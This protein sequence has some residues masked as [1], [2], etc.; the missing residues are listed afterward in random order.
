MSERISVIKEKDKLI[1]TIKAFCD[2]QKQKMLLWWIV[3]F[4]ICGIV[5]LS[6]FFGNY[7]SGTKVF[8]AVYVA[9]WI[10]FEFKVV[11]AYRWRKYGEE[12]LILENGELLLIKNIGKRGVTQRIEFEEIQKVDFY[13]DTN[14]GFIK[15]M[16]DSYWNINKYNLII[17]LEN[18]VV[19]FA[20]DITNKEAKKISHEIQ[21]FIR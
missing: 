3:L 17:K 1:I 18:S 4:T 2:Q 8:F 21:N 14:N 5:I 11:Y 12:Q 7:D 19:P 10:F 9:F 6:Q 20:I 15:S 13:S 16:N